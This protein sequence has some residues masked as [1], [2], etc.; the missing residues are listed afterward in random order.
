MNTVSDISL[1]TLNFQSLRTHIKEI[2]L[3]SR[4]TITGTLSLVRN[5][6]FTNNVIINDVSKNVA[7]LDV[8][9]YEIEILS[10]LLDA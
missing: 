4:V 3:Q 1:F 7:Y 6:C 9:V 10:Y 8:K 5:F 2:L